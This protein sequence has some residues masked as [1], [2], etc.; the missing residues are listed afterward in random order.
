MRIPYGLLLLTSL[1][2]ANKVSPVDVAI[3]GGDADALGR[4]LITQTGTDRERVAAAL[5]RLT[6]LDARA[7][8]LVPTRPG[9]QAALDKLSATKLHAIGCGLIS[10]TPTE[11][12]FRCSQRKCGDSCSV[13]RQDTTVKIRRTGYLLGDVKTQK[14]GDTGECGCCN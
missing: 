4:M 9:L 12:V 2:A 6:R 1:A 7:L 3:R 8:S 13:T 5:I 14:L 11:L 10:S